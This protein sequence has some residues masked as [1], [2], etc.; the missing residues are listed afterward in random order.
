MIKVRFFILLAFVLV[1]EK[2]LA[3]AQD[4]ISFDYRKFIVDSF[5]FEPGRSNYL[6]YGIN[7]E[8]ILL[9]IE[10]SFIKSYFISRASGQL[11]DST[12]FTK[13][14]I[15]IRAF[16]PKCYRQSGDSDSSKESARKF[17]IYLRKDN[18]VNLK[19]PVSIGHGNARSDEK[20]SINKKVHNLLFNH[21][22]YYQTKNK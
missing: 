18:V 3:Q 6:I 20:F 11:I 17:I 7:E 12:T 4:S 5:G 14:K 22:L 15:W 10:E 21:L 19:I 1:Y 9:F 8:Y 16:D 2:N 13:N